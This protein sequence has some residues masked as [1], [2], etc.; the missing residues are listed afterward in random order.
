M[1]ICWICDMQ[2]RLAHLLD[3]PPDVVGAE[4]KGI[5]PLAV[6]L[7]MMFEFSRPALVALRTRERKQFDVGVIDAEESVAGPVLRVVTAPGRRAPEQ[8]RVVVGSAL[9]V[10][11]GDDHVVERQV[12]HQPAPGYSAA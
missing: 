8:G 5:E 6:L 9:Q 11:H 1:S 4:R 12:W 2:P 7:E 3:S 10:L